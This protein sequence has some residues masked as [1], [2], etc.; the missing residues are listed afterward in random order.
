[1]KKKTEREAKSTPVSLVFLR[2]QVVEEPLSPDMDHGPS[3]LKQEMESIL[4]GARK[5]LSQDGEQPLMV[6]VYAA[7]KKFSLFP[8]VMDDRDKAVAKA[9]VT[10]FLEK[11]KAKAA[12]LVSES[13]VRPSASISKEDP[14]REEA[15]LAAAKNGREH[16]MAIQRFHRIEDGGFFFETS[17]IFQFEDGS[18]D[19]DP[20]FGTHQF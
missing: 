14:R 3:D 13:W 5:T 16:F 12:I 7:D 1:M 17:E 20:W 6:V 8:E 11:H 2:A 18:P 15:L 10:A 4:D 19:R 9:F